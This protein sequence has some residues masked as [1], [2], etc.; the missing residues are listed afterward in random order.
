MMSGLIMR[1]LMV[2][3]L[4]TLGYCWGQSIPISPC[5]D[6]FKYQVDAGGMQYGL[7]S[8]PPPEPDYNIKLTVKM[9]LDAIPPT[10]S[11]LYILCFSSFLLRIV[12][13]MCM[14]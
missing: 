2:V 13:M 7:I 5:P 6:K 9:A 14:K 10:V 3:G 1:L 11:D 4:E 12:C 8:V